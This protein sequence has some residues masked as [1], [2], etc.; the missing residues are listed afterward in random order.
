M[1]DPFGIYQQLDWL[2]Y[3]LIWI[4]IAVTVIAIVLIVMVARS[5]DES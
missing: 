5:D 1:K 4:G 3:E 2:V